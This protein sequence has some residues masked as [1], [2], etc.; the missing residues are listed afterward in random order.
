MCMKTNQ[1]SEDFNCWTPQTIF[2]STHLT[3]YAQFALPKTRA[4]HSRENSQL[5]WTDLRKALRLTRTLVFGL[6]S[7]PTSCANSSARS[8]A[9]CSWSSSQHSRFT[10]SISGRT[11]GFSFSG[12][13]WRLAAAPASAA[14]TLGAK[15]RFAVGAHSHWT[16]LESIGGSMPSKTP[17]N[18]TLYSNFRT[19]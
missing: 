6:G 8:P 7:L 19:I 10:L 2:T 11:T 16:M 15:E 4:L 13:M 3:H 17:K 5:R 14:W 12:R 1:K 9:V 18:H